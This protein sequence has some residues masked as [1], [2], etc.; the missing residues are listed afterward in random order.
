[1]GEGLQR[2]LRTYGRMIVQGEIWVWDYAKGCAV[3][4]KNMRVGSAR[5]ARSERARAELLKAEF[6]TSENR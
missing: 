6:P 1:M 3:K 2:V 4:D 5:Y